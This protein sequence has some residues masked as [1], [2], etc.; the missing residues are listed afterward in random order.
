V[1]LETG[2]R[3]PIVAL[4]GKGVTFDTGGIS[5]KPAAD[6]D[7][8]KYD[9]SGACNVLGT[10]H[11]AARLAL[12]IRLRCYLPLAENMPSGTAYRPGDII[13][14]YNNKTV[15]IT[16][17][18]AEGRLILAD[19]LALAIEERPD[20]LVEMSTLTGAAVVALGE[21]AAA[22]YCSEDAMA[23]A[24]LGS[25]DDSGE[26]LWRMP[27]WPEYVDEMKGNHADLKNSAGRWGGACTA[28]AF[29]SQFVDG[30]PRWAHLDI[31]GPAI[32]AP[33]RQATGYGVA[34]TL[35]WLASLASA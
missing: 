27:L 20:Y 29:L 9:K 1:R 16:N 7:E 6:M 22:L 33:P 30:H 3:G 12:P 11:A 24:L 23:E 17:T 35:R 31:A 8:M 26:R 15:E 18:D 34:L 19:A 28:A 10:A 2:R 5:I 14:C 4:V 25:A 32:S 13:R 21:R